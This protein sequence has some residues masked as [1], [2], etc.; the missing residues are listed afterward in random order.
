MNTALIVYVCMTLA[1]GREF[2]DTPCPTEA[3]QP[4]RPPLVGTIN[5]WPPA[6]PQYAWR[7]D[8]WP[9]ADGSRVVFHRHR[10]GWRGHHR[11]KR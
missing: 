1:G 9:S 10:H 6:P 3:A 2:R 5:E 4:A 8:Q 11:G 7:R